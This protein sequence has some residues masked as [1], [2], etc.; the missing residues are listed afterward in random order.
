MPELDNDISPVIS[1]C[2]TAYQHANYIER[3][4]DGILDQDFDLPFEILL[5]EDD[6]NDGTREICI[7]YANKFP[8]KIRLFLNSREDVICNNGFPTGKR[9]FIN[10]IKHARGKYI[11]FCDGDDYWIDDKKLIRQYMALEISGKGMCFHP[12]KVFDINNNDLGL[13]GFLGDDL[14]VLDPRFVYSKLFYGSLAP[15]QSIA[16]NRNILS[17]FST[18]IVDKSGGS[19][20]YLQMFAA[21]HGLIYLPQVM[22]VYNRG[23][24]GSMTE[25]IMKSKNLIAF[26]ESNSAAVRILSERLTGINKKKLKVA[27]AGIM[28]RLIL[29]KRLDHKIRTKLI[30]KS[31]Q[32]HGF[33]FSILALF[34]ELTSKVRKRYNFFT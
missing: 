31:I 25:Q 23:V 32:M 13:I 6:S 19:H 18:F 28:I 22:S 26:R 24:P 17:D 16:I 4:L 8:E 10:N 29:S 9:N 34:I 5:G 2:V 15:M 21:Q 11:A 12:S 20:G 3:C 30:L 14:R 33:K 27:A 7:D 1:V